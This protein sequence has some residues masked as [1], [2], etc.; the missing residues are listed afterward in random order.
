MPADGAADGFLSALTRN[1][2]YSVIVDYRKFNEI[3]MNDSYPARHK[4]FTFP[5]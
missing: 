5:S 4:P 2:H 3:T 1:E